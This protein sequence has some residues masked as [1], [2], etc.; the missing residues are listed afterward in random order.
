LI[1]IFSPSGDEPGSIVPIEN[2]F[3]KKPD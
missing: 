3:F 1:H 2:S